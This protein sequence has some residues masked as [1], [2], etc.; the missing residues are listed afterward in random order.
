MNKNKSGVC[1]SSRAALGKAVLRVADF[2]GA[3]VA[4]SYQ[5]DETQQVG[6]GPGHVGGVVA[7][8]KVPS[9]NLLVKRRRRK[10]DCYSQTSVS[11]I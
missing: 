10:R 5:T 4:G 7:A 11:Y 8:R 9:T 3:P 2:D 6:E 1:S